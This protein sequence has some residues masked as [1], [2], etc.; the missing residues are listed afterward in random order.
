MKM[1]ISR[2]RLREK[3]INDPDLD[4]EAGFPTSAFE[5][6]GMFISPSLAPANDDNV[7][8][9]KEA[10]GLFV[11]QLRRREKLSMS[12]LS[13][14][15]RI[16]EDEI[17]KIE[18]DLNHKPRPRTVHQLASVFNLPERSLMKLSGATITRDEAFQQEAFRFAAK[19]EDMAKLSHAEQKAL[20]EYIRFLADHNGG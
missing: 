4:Q 12:E 18:H 14:K 13:A 6:I 19:S 3:I 11:R 16:D 10:F 5:T 17:W 9:L 15:A 7:V 8:K 20:N 1:M 2:D